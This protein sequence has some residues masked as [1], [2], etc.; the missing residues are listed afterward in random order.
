[1]PTKSASLS[2][3]RLLL[4]RTRFEDFEPAHSS[5]V[6]NAGVLVVSVRWFLISRPL[7]YLHE[8]QTEI[9]FRYHELYPP[10]C[11]HKKV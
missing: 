8:R 1:V 6:C 7:R 4:R 9:E 3:N 10:S 5:F 2:F 11:G